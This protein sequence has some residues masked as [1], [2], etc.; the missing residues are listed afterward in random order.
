M[1]RE[2]FF[3]AYDAAMIKA[4]EKYGLGPIESI[5]EVDEDLLDYILSDD[6]LKEE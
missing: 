4:V 6:F 5:D 2:E 3:K 1:T